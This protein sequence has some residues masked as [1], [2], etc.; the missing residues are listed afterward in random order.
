MAIP[1]SE[2]I[3][4]SSG[5][6]VPSVPLHAVD[7]H[8]HNPRSVHQQCWIW[9]A[10][11]GVNSKG[12]R[13]D[14]HQSGRPESHGS[15]NQEQKSCDRLDGA[16]DES[17]KLVMTGEKTVVCCKHRLYALENNDDTQ[18]DIQGQECANEGTRRH[19]IL[20]ERM[21]HDQKSDGNQIRQCS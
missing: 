10:A 5:C 19:E 20:P 18:S 16:Q 14:G 15:G 4:S 8:K 12:E 17:E 3:A 6:G 1:R 21:E 2:S 9:L 13:K 11:Q 7:S